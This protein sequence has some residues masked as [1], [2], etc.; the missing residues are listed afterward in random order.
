[1]IDEKIKA[2]RQ[3]L[4][5][6]FKNRRE[7]MGHDLELVARTVEITSNSLKG[8]ES[9]RFAWDIDLHHR[10][11]AALEIK[12]YFSTT[13]E[14][15]G[16]KLWKADDPE[17]YYG[18]YITENLI[19]YPDQLAI[20]KLTHP[21]LFVRFNYGES[22]FSSYDDWKANHTQVE[23]LDADDKPTTEEDIDYYLTECWNFLALHEKEEERLADE[24]D[25]DEH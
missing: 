20:T 12:P 16:F 25:D 10:L 23:W 21:R 11:C 13:E 7:E 17:R 19:L 15:P 22:Y 14:P 18:F 24:F 5:S 2:A 1:M 3:Q 8:I 6:F 4:G 9:G